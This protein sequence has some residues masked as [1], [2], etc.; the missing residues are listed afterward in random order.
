M[1]S[2]AIF[3]CVCVCVYVSSLC[4]GL[5][6]RSRFTE[7]FPLGIPCSGFHLLLLYFRFF[8]VKFIS[9]FLSRFHSS[10][11]LLP[12]HQGPDRVGR[13]LPIGPRSRLF[14]LGFYRVFLLFTG[15]LGEHYRVL[16]SFL[17]TSTVT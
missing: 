16:P 5:F 13:D 3:V 8:L 12:A 11:H 14:L 17:L 6:G 4:V 15:F 2:F 9:S 7:L 1:P 10:E